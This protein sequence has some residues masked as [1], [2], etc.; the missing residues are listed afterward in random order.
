MSQ[1]R[2]FSE[3]ISRIQIAP[4]PPDEFTTCRQIAACYGMMRRFLGNLAGWRSLTDTKGTPLRWTTGL[5]IG[6]PCGRL[7]SGSA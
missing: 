4:L 3:S 6:E 7:A 2:A 5:I 1:K